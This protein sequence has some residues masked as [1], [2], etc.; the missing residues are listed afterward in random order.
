MVNPDDPSPAVPEDL[1]R[2]RRRPR[3]AGKHPRKFQEKYKE[4]R[5]DLYPETVA[6][7]LASGK[8]PAGSHVPIMVTEVLDH[9]QPRAG[10][11]LV[12]CTLGHGG[13][14][15][16]ILSR[17]Q[18]EGHLLGLDV[19]PK[20]QART[21][22]QLRK[23]GFGPDIFSVQR[24]N[25]A[26]IKRAL[27][28]QGWEKVHGILADLGVSSM[29]LDEPERGFSY[30]LEGPLDMR[31][32]PDKGSPAS[33]WIRNSTPEELSTI[34]HQNADEP[35]AVLLGQ[36]LAGQNLSSTS[37]LKMQITQAL[38][39]LNGEEQIKTM[40]R[41]FQA[42]RI[43]VNEEFKSLETLL[44]HAPDCLESGGHIVILSFHSGEDRRVKRAFQEGLQQGLYAQIADQPLRPSPAECRANP[45]A[46]ST[47]LRWARRS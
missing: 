31:M 15:R 43:A 42:L 24:S 35:Q 33:E 11:R 32:N 40:R 25:F 26:G 5:P 1:P 23:E 41:V 18:P 9:L 6:R 39:G 20:E 29:Q 27:A 14:A 13:H 7:V 45:R 16:R 3:Y 37:E 22:A 19:D 34:L 2:H 17:L 28:M 30:K 10:Q 47:K 12:D 46:S 38:P 8:T 36:E 21:E 4:L 44:K